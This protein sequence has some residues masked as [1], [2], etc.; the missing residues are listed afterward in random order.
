MSERQAIK[1][2]VG[3]S[4]S[5]A[6]EVAILAFVFGEWAAH[7]ATG[8][9]D[10]DDRWTLTHIPSGRGVPLFTE[11]QAISIARRLHE[12]GITV[13]NGDRPAAGARREIQRIISEEVARVA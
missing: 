6:K 5:T 1:I 4:T 9:Y 2:R 12:D 3:S 13:K 10:N 8:I 11:K 7:E